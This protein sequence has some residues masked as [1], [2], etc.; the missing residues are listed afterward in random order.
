MPRWNQDHCGAAPGR[1]ILPL[2]DSGNNR[3]TVAFRPEI[4]SRLSLPGHRPSAFLTEY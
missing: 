2:W 4:P 3:R 1:D